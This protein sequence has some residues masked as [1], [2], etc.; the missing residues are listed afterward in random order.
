MFS[1]VS[2]IIIIC[3]SSILCAGTLCGRKGDDSDGDCTRYAS[4]AF[5]DAPPI[6]CLG[7]PR[8]LYLRAFR[9]H[10]TVRSTHYSRVD[11]SHLRRTCSQH[12]RS[13]FTSFGAS[14]ARNSPSDVHSTLQYVDYEYILISRCAHDCNVH[15]ICSV[16]TMGCGLRHSRAAQLEWRLYVRTFSFWSTWPNTKPRCRNGCN[17]CGSGEIIVDTV[18][19]TIGKNL[20]IGT[21]HFYPTRC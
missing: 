7:R 12:S 1:R 6:S 17:E 10:R 14:T 5:P 18:C 9:S 8:S 16:Y 3:Q 20:N 4:D 15:I 19:E 11:V 2:V 21:Q 13:H